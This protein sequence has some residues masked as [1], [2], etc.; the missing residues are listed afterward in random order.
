[1]KARITCFICCIK[2]LFSVDDILYEVLIEFHERE[3]IQIVPLLAD[4]SLILFRSI[5]ELLTYVRSVNAASTLC[6]H[7][8]L[9]NRSAWQINVLHS[10]V[11]F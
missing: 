2:L 11:K 6:D 1:M 4:S 10:M 3:R 7:G 9:I 5:L 8:A